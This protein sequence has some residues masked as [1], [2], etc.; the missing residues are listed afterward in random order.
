MY[1]SGLRLI[2]NCIN[3]VQSVKMLV[4]MDKVQT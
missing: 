3:I 1:S 2:W 4:E